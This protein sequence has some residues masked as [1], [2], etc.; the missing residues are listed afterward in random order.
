MHIVFSNIYSSMEKAVEHSS[1]EQFMQNSLKEI[2]E[3]DDMKKLDHLSA[4]K[5]I[6]LANNIESVQD[7]LFHSICHVHELIDNAI[8]ARRICV[9]RLL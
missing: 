6:M 2:L 8:K 1:E 7:E 3:A 9:S 4:E 5:L